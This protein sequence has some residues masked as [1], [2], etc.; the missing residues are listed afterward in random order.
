M[1]SDQQPMMGVPVS[2]E[3]A[4]RRRGML[5]EFYASQTLPPLYRLSTMDPDV[6]WGT[7]RYDTPTTSQTRF[8]RESKATAMPSIEVHTLEFDTDDEIAKV[9][10]T[11]NFGG[12]PPEVPTQQ[13]TIPVTI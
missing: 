2:P 8:V 5:A 7:A 11:T 6:T 12:L 9:P 1:S 13:V 4:E 10:W 3:E